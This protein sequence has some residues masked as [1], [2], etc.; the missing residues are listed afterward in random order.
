MAPGFEIFNIIMMIIMT[1]KHLVWS[2]W[3]T[4]VWPGF[5]AFIFIGW[6]WRLSGSVCQFVS[7]GGGGGGGGEKHLNRKS[8]N[9]LSPWWITI[10]MMDKSMW[11][12]ELILFTHISHNALHC[13]AERFCL[14]SPDRRPSGLW[15]T[16]CVQV[17]WAPMPPI[18]LLQVHIIPRRKTSFGWLT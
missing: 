1:N 5:S 14:H 3:T 2:G 6:Q 16:D 10:T 18:R 9:C 12:E 7:R 11:T 15:Q 4:I 13:R 17:I 8:V